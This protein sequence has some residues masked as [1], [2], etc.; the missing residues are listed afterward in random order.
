MDR[1]AALR[2][3]AAAAAAAVVEQGDMAFDCYVVT[4]KT[5]VDERV[6]GLADINPPD[7]PLP[8]SEPPSV[9]RPDEQCRFLLQERG[10]WGHIKNIIHLHRC[11]HKTVKLKLTN[12]NPNPDPNRYRRRCPDHNARIQNSLL[13]NYKLKRKIQI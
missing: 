1:P 7:I 2:Y 13:R 10:F 4:L 3:R 5:A 12:T 6:S 8:G 9:A 11:K